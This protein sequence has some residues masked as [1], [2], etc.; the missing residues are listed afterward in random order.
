M[1]VSWIRHLPIIAASLLVTLVSACNSDL[2]N[3]SGTSTTTASATGIWSGTDSVSGLGVTAY[4]NS[5]GE[6]A[7]VRSDG[8]QFTGTV[9]LS[10]DTLAAT[11]DGYSDFGNTFSDGSTYGIGTVNGTVSTGATLT[12]TLSFTTNGNTAITGDWSLTFQ[13]LSNTTSSDSAVS[14]NY[15]N[16]VTG[17]VLSITTSGTMTSQN[18]NNSCVLN[19]T[20][21]T[22]DSSHDI[23][24]VSYQYEDCTGSYAA[25]NGVQFTGLAVLNSTLSTP[26]LSIVVTGASSTTKYGIVATYNAS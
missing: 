14:A 19:G 18:A 11:V 13:S 21:S 16:T 3:N 20:I 2:D 4:I 8:I 5:A 6:A 1:R 10:G 25:L 7:F 9:Q 15:T 24:E 23:Y 17:E 12:A 22:S 26:Q